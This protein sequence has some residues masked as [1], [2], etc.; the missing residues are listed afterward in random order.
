V[1]H[2]ALR[3]VLDQPGVGVALWG[4]RR[5][6]QVDAV[7]GAFGFSLDAAT[8]AEIDRIVAEEVHSPIGAD[9]MAPPE[10]VGGK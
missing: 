9:F 5:P 10:E 4:A 3:W 7:P 6:E 1:I 2:L 8:K